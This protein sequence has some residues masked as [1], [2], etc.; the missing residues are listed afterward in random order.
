MR[1]P[2]R[3]SARCARRTFANLRQQAELQLYRR[4]T[5]EHKLELLPV[6]PE[7]GFA[8]LPEPNP[9]DIWLDLE[10]HPWFEPARGLEY[11][12]GWIELDEDGRPR[13]ECLW[14]H[15]RR[16]EKTSFERLMDAI[17]ERRRRFPGMHV[18]H[19]ASYE[20]HGAQAPHG[21]ARHARGASS[22]TSS[23]ARC[24]SISTG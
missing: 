15:D 3:A 13:Y 8:L 18:Y 19:Y 11:L 23:A 16:E 6:E 24:S 14:A 22:T 21:R 2:T 7:R 4:R 20:A 5:G 10:G 1:R 9:G 17:A 12:F